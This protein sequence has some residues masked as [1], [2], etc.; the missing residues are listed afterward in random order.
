[1]TEGNILQS[2]SSL[3]L[4]RT[5]LEIELNSPEAI[6][7]LL[8]KPLGNHLILIFGHHRNLFENYHELFAKQVNEDRFFR[9]TNGLGYLLGSLSERDFARWLFKGFELES[10]LLILTLQPQTQS[11]SNLVLFRGIRMNKNP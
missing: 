3:N 9:Q 11:I 2:G 10:N 7:Q 1:M 5:Q 8:E 4:F 6:T